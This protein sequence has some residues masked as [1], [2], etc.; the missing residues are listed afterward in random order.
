MKTRK[1]RDNGDGC[2]VEATHDAIGAKYKGMMIYHLLAGTM[3]FSDFQRLMPDVSHRM[4][5]RQLRE[6]EA[7]G[8]VMRKVI[9]TVPPGTEYSLTPLGRALEPT[10]VAMY[11]WG[12]KLL[13]HRS[14]AQTQGDSE[15]I[16]RTVI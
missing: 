1:Y 3:R 2:P 5:T 11:E 8:I 12:Q 10:V 14:R 7:T 6:L 15:A 9:P 4:L 16:G 13:A